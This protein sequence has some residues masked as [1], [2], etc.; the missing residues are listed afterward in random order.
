MGTALR[1]MGSQG[2]TTLR[3]LAGA[4][5]EPVGQR[6]DPRKTFGG[7]AAA[8]GFRRIQKKVFGVDPTPRTGRG[9]T[10]TGDSTVAFSGIVQSCNTSVKPF[11]SLCFFLSLDTRSIAEV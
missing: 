7:K 8:G 5:P 1:K 11:V 9:R 6:K 2:G 4:E 10:I 3:A